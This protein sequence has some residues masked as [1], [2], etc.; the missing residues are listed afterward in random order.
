M[1]IN[2]KDTFMSCDATYKEANVVLFGADFDGTVSFRPGTRF[3]PAAIRAASYG[4]ETWS[5]AIEKDLEDIQVF[6]YADLQLTCGDVKQAHDS[7]YQVTQAIIADNKIPFMLGGEHS[8]TYPT[9]NALRSKH[10]S[11]VL[12]Q[13]D[14]HADMRDD[15]MGVKESHASV[16]KRIINDHESIHVYQFGIRSATQ[17]EHQL[18]S[19]NKTLYPFD[20][21]QIAQVIDE[22]KGQPVYLTVD[23]DVL[24]PS[25][26][27]GTGTPEPGGVSFNE[28]IEA[29]KIIASS[30]IVGMDVMELSPHYDTSDVS[31]VVAAKVVREM[32]L[33]VGGKHGK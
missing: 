10:S 29:I 9:V 32:L 18:M 13:L 30:D 21:K 33:L 12:I 3:G 8:C 31:S 5:M 17:H 6:D 7:I 2:K 25:V 11:L 28:L 4:L 27:P 20:L 1:L 26:L 23:L 14:A 24:D 19:K 16:I 22:I 15:Y